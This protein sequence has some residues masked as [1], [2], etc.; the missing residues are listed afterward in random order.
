MLN[1]SNSTY[2]GPWVVSNT[3]KS[4]ATSYTELVKVAYSSD[5]TLSVNQEFKFLL[6]FELPAPTLTVA[7]AMQ[8]S[9]TEPRISS[10][11]DILR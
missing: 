9:K 1:L 2:F 10:D 4:K 7:S 8:E 6:T 11:F 5:Y 3:V